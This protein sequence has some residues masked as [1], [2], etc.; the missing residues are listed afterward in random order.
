MYTLIDGK[1]VA[2]DIRR[3]ISEEVAKIK[4]EGGKVPNLVTILVGD[5][6][7]SQ[8]YVAN[9]LK[10]CQEV[11]FESSLV[12]YDTDISESEVLGR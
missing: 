10:D 11:G 7:S 9:K 8:S 5:N 12:K 3:E 4:K 6:A 2:S 1:K